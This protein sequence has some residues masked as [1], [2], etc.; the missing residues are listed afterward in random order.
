[1]HHKSYPV[2]CHPSCLVASCMKS[3]SNDSYTLRN[4][5]CLYVT[6]FIKI[7]PS[8]QLCISFLHEEFDTRKSNSASASLI[9]RSAPWMLRQILASCTPLHVYFQQRDKA[10]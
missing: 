5:N 9:F 4:G 2:F 6:D 8:F 3:I 1:M 7:V 10:E